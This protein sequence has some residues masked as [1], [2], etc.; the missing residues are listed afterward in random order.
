MCSVAIVWAVTYEEMHQDL[1]GSSL[2]LPGG[3]GTFV[4]VWRCNR[5]KQSPLTVFYCWVIG[6]NKLAFHKLNCQGGLSC[7]NTKEYCNQGPFRC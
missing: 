7:K 1:S 5:P 6:V 3:G 2:Q 4:C